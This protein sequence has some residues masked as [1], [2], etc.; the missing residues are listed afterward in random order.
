MARNA[1]YVFPVSRLIVSCL[2][3]LTGVCECVCVCVITEFIIWCHVRRRL[4]LM[5]IK[6]LKRSEDMWWLLHIAG[7]TGVLWHNWTVRRSW[8]VSATYDFYQ[9]EMSVLFSVYFVSHIA[10]MV[11]IFYSV[12][13]KAVTQQ[14][15]FSGL[16]DANP[17]PNIMHASVTFNSN[18][19]K[20]CVYLNWS[21]SWMWLRG[22]RSLMTNRTQSNI[23]I[24]LG[25]PLTSSQVINARV[26]ASMQTIR[27]FSSATLDTFTRFKGF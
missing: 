14:K 7:D 3:L 21:W 11:A 8:C 1:F 5:M 23:G 13:R 16:S 4:L 2:V 18:F 15:L 17:F 25:D 27:Q 12:A 24:F 9:L 19:I 22:R 26:L 10:Y 6:V 20:V